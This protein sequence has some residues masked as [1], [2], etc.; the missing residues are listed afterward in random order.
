[1]PKKEKN[2]QRLWNRRHRKNIYATKQELNLADK[3][4]FLPTINA[5]NNV[6]IAKEQLN[7]PKIDK[8]NYGF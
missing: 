7:L 1:L 4:L 2:E 6:T 3:N 5:L 8:N